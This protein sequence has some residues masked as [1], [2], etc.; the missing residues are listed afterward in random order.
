MCTDSVEL[1]ATPT[2]IATAA[3]VA[4]LAGAGA[5]GKLLK[6]ANTQHALLHQKQEQGNFWSGSVS[7]AY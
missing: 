2:A 3:A 1:A 6:R 7:I 4:S 5:S